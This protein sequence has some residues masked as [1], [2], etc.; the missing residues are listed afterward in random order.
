MIHPFIRRS[1]RPHLG[2][3]ARVAGWAAALAL[4]TACYGALVGPLLRALFGGSLIWPAAVR[5]VLPVAPDAETLRLWLPALLVGAAVLKGLAQHRHAVGVADLGQRVLFDLRARLHRRILDLPPDAVARIGVADLHSRALH[6][7]DA[8]ERWAVQG[9]AIRV[10]DGA[11]VVALLTLCLLIEWR[12]ALVVFGTYPLVFWPIARIGSRLRRAAGQSQVAHAALQIELDDQLRRLALV[13]LSGDVEQANLRHQ[14][15]NQALA[16]ARVHQ[17]RTRALAPPL[18]EIVGAAALAAT[19]VYAGQRITN[20][21]LAAEHVLSFFVAVLMLYQPVK[22]LVRTQAIV[23]PGRAALARLEEVLELTVRLP[24]GGDAP[25]PQTAPEVRFVGVDLQRGDRQVL[26]RVNLRLPRGEMTALCGA[27]GAGKTTIAWLLARLLDPT[28]GDVR[29]NDR[30]LRNIDALAWRRQVGWVTQQPMLG[31]GT[32]RENLSF[33][34]GTAIESGAEAAG[35][36]PVIARLP[37]GWDTPLGDDGAGLSGGEQ[38]RVAL[39][40]ALARQ[41][42]VLILDE[43][44]AHLDAEARAGLIT[45]LKSLRGTMT[46]LLITHDRALAAGAD[47]QVAIDG[48]RVAG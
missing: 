12:L 48:G 25:A 20:G 23:Q 27:N 34:G 2:Q 9:T 21:T 16:D 45:Q 1:L 38:Q 15:A 3:A 6:D 5:G 42:T 10:R 47:H 43:P 35:L 30:S 19:L 8:I 36:L 33:G 37:L 40:R 4:L 18:N 17:V 11:Q 46:I 14:A 29:V 41:P 7:V 13:Q 44:T 32:L 26:H 39:A 31:R 22:G 28:A 24:S